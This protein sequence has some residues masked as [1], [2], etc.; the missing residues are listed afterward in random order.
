MKRGIVCAVVGLF[1]AV[2]IAG[3]GW[4]GEAERAKVVSKKHTNTIMK[5]DAQTMLK[6]KEYYQ[7]APRVYIDRKMMQIPFKTSVNLLTHLQYTPSERDQGQCGDCWLWAGTGVMEIA[8]S[9]QNSVKDRLS[10]QYVNSCNTT[11]NGYA[12]CGGNTGHVSNIYSTTGLAIPWS[13]TNASFQDGGRTCDNGSSLVSCSSIATSPNYGI[14][15]IS[16][17]VIET[18]NQDQATAIA[19]IKAVLNQNKAIWFAFTLANDSDWQVFFDHWNNQSES[20]VFSYDSLSGHAYIDGEGGGHA[21]LLVGYDDSGANPY[22]VMLNSWGTTTN[23]PNGL[24]RVAMNSNYNDYFTYEG[25]NYGM[26]EFWEIDVAFTGGTVTTTIGPN[27]TTTIPSSTTTIGN[28]PPSYPVDCGGGFCCPIDYPVCCNSIGGCCAQQYPVCCGDGYCYANAPDCTCP[29]EQALSGDD[30]KLDVLREM[31]D[32]RMRST[33]KGQ[34]LVDLYYEHAE[35]ILKILS[36]HEVLMAH[37]AVV[38]NRVV[39]KAMLL[40]TGQAVTIDQE[41][42][43]SILEVADAI[44]ADASPDLKMA[45]K[46]VKN[47]ITTES[48]FRELGIPAKKK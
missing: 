42:S 48:I 23:R 37:T 38:I 44:E 45:I 24:M 34:L 8:H 3:N 47:G 9:V 16:D 21:I 36:A 19:N 30:S 2:V 14:T 5:L 41:L 31:R 17:Q 25:S 46:L 27:T 18:L 4:T 11:S 35:E 28:C 10:I 32:T 1:L 20:D 40:N 7:N 39:E 43:D 33:A 12:C 26:I 6:W 22:W 29:V 13:N 15:S